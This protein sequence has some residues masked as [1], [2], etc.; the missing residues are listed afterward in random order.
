M[1]WGRI[2]LPVVWLCLL[3]MLLA[4]ATDA[5]PWWAGIGALLAGMALYARLGSPR[6]REPVPVAAPVVGRWRAV[7]SPANSVP[8]HGLHAYGQTYAIDL[9]HEPAGMPRPSFGWWPFGRRPA[10]FPGFGAE[11]LAPSPGVVVEAYDRA[12]DHWSRTS[13][14]ALLYL[15]VESAIRELTGPGRILGNRIVLELGDGLYAVLAHLRR[16]SIRVGPGDVVATGDRLADCGN[17]GNSTEPHVHFQL[18]DH[19]S[20]L[21]A[22]GVP[23]SFY[24][25]GPRGE[26]RSLGVPRKGEPFVAA[27]PPVQIGGSP[28][29][30]R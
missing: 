7:N 29:S 2:R 27:T 21:L 30:G 19:A 9:I 11:V 28:S 3:V 23:F 15:L 22:D 6:A 5:V 8:S 20:V 1:R 24:E 18:M 16:G 25:R 13:Y 4:S 17:S 26:H 12:R 14:P 10:N